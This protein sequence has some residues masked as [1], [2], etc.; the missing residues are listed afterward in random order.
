MISQP[1]E[2]LWWLGVL[3]DPLV[4]EMCGQ[5]KPELLT[6]K[7]GEQVRVVMACWRRDDGGSKGS[8]WTAVRRACGTAAVASVARAR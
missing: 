4:R 8:G 5:S 3:Y 7:R 6:T 1:D 2:L